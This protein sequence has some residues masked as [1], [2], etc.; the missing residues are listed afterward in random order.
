MI[1]LPTELTITQVN[2]YKSKFIEYVDEH[3]NI[4]IDDSDVERIDTIGL[5]LLLSFVIYI[6]FKNKTLRWNNQSLII[7][8]S[9]KQLG[10]TGELINKYFT[11]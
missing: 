1:K 4:E 3:E 8:N 9:A 6:N 10:I 11:V 5:Q 7:R 2:D